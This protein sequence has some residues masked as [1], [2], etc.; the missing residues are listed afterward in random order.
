MALSATPVT[1]TNSGLQ[2]T[3]P[4]VST[5]THTNV[6]S[7][8]ADTVLLAA[9]TAR[10]PGSTIANDST[11]ILYVKLGSGASA[12]SYQA[13]V[14]AKTTV[15]GLFLVPDSYTGAVNGFWAAANGFARVVELT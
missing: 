4:T 13:A 8:N 3:P 11:A 15:P 6:A 7:A 5:A 2:A 12:T 14:D 10:Q 9:N 1:F